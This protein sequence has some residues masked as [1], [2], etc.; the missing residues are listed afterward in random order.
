MAVIGPLLL[1]AALTFLCYLPALQAGFIWDDGEY[2]T[3]NP[4]L[5]SLAG[6]RAIWTRIGATVQYY[7]LTFTA[8]WLQYHLWGLQPAGYHFVNILLHAATAVLLWRVL[9]RLG[10]PTAWLAAA[11]FAVHPVHVACVA[12]I[13]ELKNILSA[14]LCLASLYVYLQWSPALAAAQPSRHSRLGLSFLLFVL[15]LLAKTV[16]A[17]LPVVILILIWWKQGRIRARDIWPLLPYFAV[18]L[19]MG[20]LTIRV[21]HDTAGSAEFS[22]TLSRLDRILVAGRVAAFYIGKLLWPAPLMLVYPRWRID[23]SLWWQYLYP[24]AV[25]LGVLV[26]ALRRSRLGRGPIAALLAYLAA[27]FPASGFFDVSFQLLHAFVADYLLYLASVP[28]I[29][30]ALDAAARLT[31]AAVRPMQRAAAVARALAAV[32]L[33]ALMVLTW[34]RASLYRDNEKLW[35]DTLSRNPASWGAWNNLGEALENKGDLAGADAAYAAALRIRSDY[36]RNLENRGRILLQ[37]GRPDEA[38]A[39]YQSLVQLRPD[40]GQAHTNL[41]IGYLMKREFTL[42]EQHLR[43]ALETNPGYAQAHLTYGHML[44]LQGSIEAALPWYQKAAALSPTDADV[45]IKVGKTLRAN[46]RPDLAVPFLQDALRL[47]PGDATAR[48]ELEQAVRLPRR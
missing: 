10:L 44:A 41:A 14:L 40:W 45:R 11:V 17:P 29:V 27:L 36:P 23:P 15:A 25:L 7:P 21:E 1:L 13:T 42:A 4:L 33:L 18:A 34:Q 38:I 9:A 31:K 5:S 48:Q 43:T 19:G 22:A 39:V 32:M 26:L 8:F 6:L 30:L 20:L 28:V 3:R 37:L 46:G 24:A 35:R 16:V 47:R 12:W 2:V